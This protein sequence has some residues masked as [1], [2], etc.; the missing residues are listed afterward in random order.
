MDEGDES[1]PDESQPMRLPA[2][3]SATIQV[4][5]PFLR[6]TEFVDWTTRPILALAVELGGEEAE[7][8]DIARQCF[9]WVRDQV[10]HTVD[11]GDD[12]ITA[13]ASDV[14]RE[15]T[16]FCFAKCHL[17]V[18]LLR[19]NGI[20]AGF[21][22]QRI[23]LDDERRA[24]CLHGLVAVDLPGYGWYRCDPRGNT[25]GVNAQFTPPAERLAFRANRPGEQIFPKV[26]ADPVG[27]VVR[28][29]SVHQRANVLAVCLPDAA[30]QS[31]L[32][33]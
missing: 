6:P 24:F 15:G 28:A 30:T 27:I 3:M 20:R 31:E 12:I 2:S 13:R 7:T 18:A 32:E 23:A 11:H 4:T 19:A 8:P 26:Y 9:E 29:L 10:H 5:D 21:V 1:Q 14:L 22:Y 16:G 17:L 25:R 33:R